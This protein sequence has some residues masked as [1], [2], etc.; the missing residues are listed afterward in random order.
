LKQTS[1]RLSTAAL[2]VTVPWVLGERNEPTLLLFL[3]P[4]RLI[5]TLGAE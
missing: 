1:E 5:N 4:A 3:F 2:G